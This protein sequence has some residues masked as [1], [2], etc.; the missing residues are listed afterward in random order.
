MAP[1]ETRPPIFLLAMLVG[2]LLAMLV[3]AFLATWPVASASAAG[4]PT[5]GPHTA[6]T[7]VYQRTWKAVRGEF[8]AV[9]MPAP[10]VHFSAR[11]RLEMEVERTPDGNRRVQVYGVQREALSGE[12]SCRE[13][14]AARESLLH[15]F[16]HVYQAE[17]WLGGELHPDDIREEIPEGLAEAE[18]QWLM[19]K[20]YGL[21]LAAYDEPVWEI[22]DAYARQ[23]RREL[24]RR[25]IRRGQF[26]A[27][28]GRDPRLIP[29]RE[30]NP[31]AEAPRA[32]D[33]SGAGA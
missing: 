18:A 8:G 19:Q 1:A 16:A 4:A 21:A 31:V 2:V 33:A 28:W 7:V 10:R 32:R 30:P 20:V 15:E 6:A 22:Y 23:I 26:G 5:C 17:P 25:L 27:N 9:G 29:W 12:R 3:G 13:L 24:P 14:L 11:H